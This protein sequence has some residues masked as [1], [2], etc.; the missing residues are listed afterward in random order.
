MDVTGQTL[1]DTV[2]SIGAR[3]L[4]RRID[5]GHEEVGELSR[6][7]LVLERV[8]DFMLRHVIEPTPANY[9]LIY[10][11]EVAREPRLE[12]AVSSMIRSGHAPFGAEAETNALIEEDLTTL[13]AHAQDNL[14]A[15]EE[16][17]RESGQD[18]KGFGEALESQLS[19]NPA[20]DALIGLTR[21]M[22]ERTKRAEEEL[23]F[24]GRAMTDLQ[25]SLA[26]ARVKADTDALTGL[27]NRRAFERYLGAA[28]ARAA[29]SGRPLSL[30]ICDLDR[31]KVIN[32]THGH[33]AGDRVLQFVSTLLQQSC[34]AK[35]QVSRHG[36]EEFV[37]VFE[38]T[39]ADQAYE[40]IDAVRRDLLSRN[41]INRETGE[42]LGAISFSAGIGL[43]GADGDVGRML[44]AADRALYSAKAAG[45][46]RVL[47]APHT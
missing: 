25:T 45:R 12:S 3:L 22:I 32:D 1:G 33:C 28:G 24:R 7:R 18:T 43:L 46:D 17:V 29:M 23:K 20:I 30:A 16:L 40:I 11:S 34:G 8:R 42:S 44:R 10:R 47:I 35:A 9:S 13:I 21:T 31:F 41:L 15:V 4:G 38:E 26:D 37:V 14:K 39:N 5:A 2:K 6:Y 36:G 19:A 27:N